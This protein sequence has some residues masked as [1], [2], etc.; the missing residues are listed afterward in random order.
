MNPTLATRTVSTHLSV[1]ASGQLRDDHSP[2]PRSGLVLTPAVLL[3]MPIDQLLYEPTAGGN[4][5]AV[6]FSGS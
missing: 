6:L 4:P 3:V 5:P 1:V 2:P